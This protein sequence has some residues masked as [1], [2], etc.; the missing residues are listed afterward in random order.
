MFQN[1][2]SGITV[3]DPKT[4]ACYLGDRQVR[5]G[6]SPQPSPSNP[7]HI[8]VHP[9]NSCLPWLPPGH[10]LVPPPFPSSAAPRALSP[11]LSSSEF[12]PSLLEACPIVPSHS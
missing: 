10:L 7:L 2:V 11:S 6:G 5:D 12:Q 9:H 8:S 3:L 4:W 1:Q